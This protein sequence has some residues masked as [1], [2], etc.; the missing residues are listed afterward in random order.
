MVYRG[1]MSEEPAPEPAVKKRK[2]RKRKRAP[3]EA[4]AAAPALRP[5]LDAEG[6]ERP[7]FLLSFPHDPQLEPAIA[8]FEAGNYAR[9]RELTPPLLEH[10]SEEVRRAAAELRRRIEPDPLMKYLLL[11][12]ALLVGA[13][14]LYAYGT[15]GAHA[16]R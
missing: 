1:A 7:R 4:E 14:L 8:A 12:V 10:D 16:H 11:A 6:H 15:H 9:V 13:L 5:E 2:K 3:A